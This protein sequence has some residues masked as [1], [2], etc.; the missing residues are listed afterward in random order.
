MDK[1]ERVDTELSPN[2]RFEKPTVLMS[3]VPDTCVE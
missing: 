3:E 1:H 2:L